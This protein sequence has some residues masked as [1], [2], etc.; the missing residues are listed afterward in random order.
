MDDKIKQIIFDVIDEVNM[1]LPGDKQIDKSVDADLYGGRG[2]LDSLGLV[3]FIILM[4]Q[5]IEDEFGATLTLA[6]QRAMSQENSPF[7]TV[8][9]LA[10]HIDLLIKEES[11]E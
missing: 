8:M 7:R 2:K 6:N 4:E 9:M 5:K 3:N 1:E 11:D 10:D